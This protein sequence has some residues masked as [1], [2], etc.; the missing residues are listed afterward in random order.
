MA[1]LSS[2]D[3][4]LNDPIFRRIVDL[5]YVSITDYDYTPTELREAAM[6][7]AEKYEYLHVRPMMFGPKITYEKIRGEDR[8]KCIAPTQTEP[9]EFQIQ[10]CV[11]LDSPSFTTE[12]Y[13]T[14]KEE[15]FLKDPTRTTKPNIT[16]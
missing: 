15:F 10:G 1:R 5:L 8:E 4:Y 7:A 3:R 14:V 16:R 13:T 9:V 12:P 6:M 11:Q 2:H